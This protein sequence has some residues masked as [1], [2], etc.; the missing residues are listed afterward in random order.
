MSLPLRVAQPTVPKD[1]R[2]RFSGMVWSWGL[3]SI[4][5]AG[6]EEAEG[7]A[8]PEADRLRELEDCNNSRWGLDMG[9]VVQEPSKYMLIAIT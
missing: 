6:V 1:P 3:C 8:L 9:A 7:V 4:S 5:G 2:Y